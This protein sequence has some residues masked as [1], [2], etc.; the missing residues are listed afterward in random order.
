MRN[1]PTW[2]LNANPSVMISC[3]LVWQMSFGSAGAYDDHVRLGKSRPRGHAHSGLFLVST[4]FWAATPF[5]AG[6]T[7]PFCGSSAAHTTVHALSGG[8]GPK[9]VVTWQSRHIFAV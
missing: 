1:S 5:G 9:I 6:A 7:G 2:T 4:D 8:T 3:V